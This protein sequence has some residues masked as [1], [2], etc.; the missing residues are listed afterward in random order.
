MV[1]LNEHDVLLYKFIMAMEHRQAI[2][3]NQGKFVLRNKLL[4]ER[5]IQINPLDGL[6]VK[7]EWVGAWSKKEEAHMLQL[8][9]NNKHLHFGVFK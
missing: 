2:E 7:R 3:R 4:S 1:F 5:N 8:I 6:Q 9:L